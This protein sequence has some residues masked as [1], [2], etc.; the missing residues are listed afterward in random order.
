[1]PPLRLRPAA[2]REEDDPR[3]F[4]RHTA[5]AEDDIGTATAAEYFEP[6]CSSPTRLIDFGVI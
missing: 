4:G 2:V 3:L 6:T 1:M 5:A